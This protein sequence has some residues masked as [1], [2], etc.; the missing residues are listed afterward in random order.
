VGRKA[1][2][3]VGRGLDWAGV[4]GMAAAVDELTRIA[5]DDPTW[6]PFKSELSDDNQS[7]VWGSS[8]LVQYPP[9]PVRPGDEWQRTVRQPRSDRP[10][11]LYSY[12]C[13]LRQVESGRDGRVAVID[14]RGSIS[15]DDSQTDRAAESGARTRLDRGRFEGQARFSLD[16]N[17]L[18]SQETVAELKATV[19]LPADRGSAGGTIDITTVV[20]SRVLTQSQ[21]ARDDER[22]Q[23]RRR[24][25]GW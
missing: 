25:G 19:T 18:V 23:R 8:R 3:R 10:D 20:T 12:Q 7:Y 24:A 6:P 11:M 17:E 15:Q 2:L 5:G 22:G 16:R 13:S 14:F 4:T 1:M 21:S 9:G